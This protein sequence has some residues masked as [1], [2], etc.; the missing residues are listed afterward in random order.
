M[1]LNE[2]R[3]A[4]DADFLRLKQL[5]ENHDGWDLV[6]SKKH[7]HVWTKVTPQTDFKII[8]VCRK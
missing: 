2:V 5:C 4:D 7:L 1:D 8:K 3:V 6:Y